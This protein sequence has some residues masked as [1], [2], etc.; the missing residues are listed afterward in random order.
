[1]KKKS[2]LEINRE[3]IELVQGI[4]ILDKISWPKEVE[5][6]FFDSRLRKSKFKIDF[7]YPKYDFHDQRERLEKLKKL[8][9]SEDPLYQF[10][11]STIESYCKS[12][13]MIHSVGSK[14]FED[15]SIEVYGKPTHLLFG[16]KYSHLETAKIFIKSLEDYEHPYMKDVQN[17]ISAKDL[18]K[19]L[20]S[21]S[22][23][24][25]GEYSPSVTLSDTLVSKAAAGKSYVRLRK[26]EMFTGYD[27]DQ[28]LVHEIMTHSLTAINGSLQEKLPLLSM[29]AART[30]KT[31]EGLATFSE[32]ITGSLDLSRLKRIC[33]R[34][35]ALDMAL[36]G[37]DFYELFNFFLSHNS[38]NEKD[39]YLSASRILRGGYA[40]GGICFTKDGVYLEGLIRVHSFFRWAFKSGNLDL[41]HLLFCGR[42][43]INDIFLLSPSLENGDISAPKFL[44]TWYTNI[45]LFAGKLAFSLILN[46]IDLDLVEKH[47][48]TKNLKAAA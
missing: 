26:G 45:D 4:K 5:R 17:L 22:T 31:Q 3:V 39:C 12:F 8:V 16:S 15:L 41:V 27:H 20:Q 14:D 1:M 42:L 40:S 44:P 21:E 47:F 29:G 36:N 19:K 11:A 46:G 35:I 43:D 34:V 2:L 13:D 23:K 28:L 37:A 9:S 38:G 48:S 24:F 18:R 10:T 33:L 7:K 32:I 25:F 30:T 6:D